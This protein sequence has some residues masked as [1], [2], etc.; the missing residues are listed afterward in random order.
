[1]KSHKNDIRYQ[2]YRSQARNLSTELIRGQPDLLREGI[3]PL[4]V[5]FEPITNE[6]IEASLLWGE[7][8]ELYPWEDVPSWMAKD[9]KGF[10]LSLW[11]GPELCG[12]CYATPKQ[13]SIC[14]KIILLEGKP[15][16]SH[17]LKGEV[18][19][20]ALL[21]IEYYARMIKC[22]EI[23]VQAPEPL[24]VPWYQELGFDYTENGRLVIQVNA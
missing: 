16:C 2:A 18:A 5:R 23:E 10:D 17:P 20:L 22:T 13:S 11:Y 9:R 24:V 12:L 3:D 19:S 21:A 6:A 7:E 4:Q 15:D 14:I 8:S 1:M